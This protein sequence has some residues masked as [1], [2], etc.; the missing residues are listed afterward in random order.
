MKESGKINEM[1]LKWIMTIVFI[2]DRQ[3]SIRA[4]LRRSLGSG[5]AL[6]LLVVSICMICF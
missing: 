5:L 2:K 1:E 6:K 4:N 3:Q